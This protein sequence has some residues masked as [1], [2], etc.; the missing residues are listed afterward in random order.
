[1]WPVLWQACRQ[2]GK[3]AD[4]YCVLLVA[5]NIAVSGMLRVCPETLVNPEEA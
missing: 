4:H 1:M 3:D 2:G 5:E